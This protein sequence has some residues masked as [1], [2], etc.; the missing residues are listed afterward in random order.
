MASDT[1]Q[2]A[3]IGDYYVLIR[4]RA[5]SRFQDRENTDQS[6]ARHIR[7][8]VGERS[9]RNRPYGRHSNQLF[10]VL[11]SSRRVAKRRHEIA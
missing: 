5:E 10:H 6:D 9:H 8:G 2:N 3:T 7:E 4:S 1:Y 11:H